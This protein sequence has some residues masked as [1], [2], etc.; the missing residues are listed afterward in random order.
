MAAY[1]RIYGFGHL[2]ADCRGPGSAT[3]TLRSASYRVL[4]NL[5]ICLFSPALVCIHQLGTFCF[6]TVSPLFFPEQMS[7][8][9]S[10]RKSRKFASVYRFSPNRNPATTLSSTCPPPPEEMCGKILTYLALFHTIED[11][12]ISYSSNRL[13]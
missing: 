6:S 3:E 1:S 8:G 7:L 2:R 9:S 12:F 13:D 4:D 5:L 10:N 11:G